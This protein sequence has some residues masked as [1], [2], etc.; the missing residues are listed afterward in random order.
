MDEQ[1]FRELLRSTPGDGKVLQQYADWLMDRGDPRGSH[2]NAELAVYR[3]EKA[4]E[5]AK[6]ERA[7][8]R[9]SQTQHFDWLNQVFPLRTLAPASGTIYRAAAP[10]EP[11]FVE[12]GTMVDADTEIAIIE[13]R[14]IFYKIPAAHGGLVTDVLFQDCA[15]VEM[16]DCLLR[17]IRPKRDQIPDPGK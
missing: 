8:Y 4:L 15:N 11:P 7:Y 17:V 9:S 3:A 13:S 14:K 16:G 12:V 5:E 6:S 1:S 10:G 2:L